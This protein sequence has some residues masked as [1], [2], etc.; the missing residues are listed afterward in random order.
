MSISLG[1]AAYFYVY[2]YFDLDGIPLYVGKG[3]GKRWE[4]LD[5]H[6][7][8]NPHFLRK[9]A[10]ARREG[11]E[12]P[13]L[14]VR[15]NLT[16]AEAFEIEMA[17]IKAIGRRVT[18][19]GP[20]LNLTEGGQGISGFKF[21]EETLAK[22]RSAALGRVVS[23]ETRAKISKTSKG[24]PKHPGHGAKVSAARKGKFP[25]TAESRA[26]ISAARTGKKYGPRGPISETVRENLR[27]K[28]L[29]KKASAETRRKMSAAH[30][31]KPL[32]P[33]REETK[34]KLRAARLGKK[35]PQ[36]QWVLL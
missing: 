26:K 32:G 23:V 31:G 15:D 21:S 30:L 36:E 12:L 13:R 1:L 3:H 24:R 29:G 33:M 19:D 35:I 9:V 7:C 16:E 4:R 11:R 18:G 14:K 8:R 27:L 6:S 17:L 10:K 28:N 25:H 2:I 34:A 5:P 20:L 22:M